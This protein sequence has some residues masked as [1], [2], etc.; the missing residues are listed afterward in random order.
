LATLELVGLTRRFAAGVEALSGLDL[1][2]GDGERVAV[3]GPSGSGKTTLLR[4]VAGLDEPS[5]GSVRINGRAV[6]RQSPAERD[7]ALVFQNPALYPHLDVFEN[8]AFGLRA[9]REDRATIRERVA[10]TARWLCIDGLLA[11]RPAAL[12]G[13]EK[14]RVALGR[15]LAR[16]PRILMLDEP[17]SS[18]DA[19]LRESIRN[20]LGDLQRRLGLTTILVTHD[21]DEALA[22]GD[23]VAVLD[24]GRLLQCGRPEDV[25]RRPATRA[26]ARFLGSPPMDLLSGRIVEDGGTLG[27][28]LVGD[29]RPTSLAPELRLPVGP[30]DLGIRAEDVREADEAGGPWLDRDGRIARAELA[31]GTLR[32]AVELDAGRGVVHLRRPLSDRRGPGDPIRVRILLSAASWFDPE[33]GRR[34]G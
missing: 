4:L 31:E 34:I 32:T 10:E 21:Q 22:W 20:D 7:V 15:A 30:I 3:V 5:A 13:G 25:Y 19:P 26:V 16:R 1:D 18:L 9:R 2:L 11:R 33:T 12:S 23:R 27:Y 6:D 29:D 14:Q 28:A 24:R 17:F 8:M